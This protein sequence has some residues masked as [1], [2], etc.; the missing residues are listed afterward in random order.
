MGGGGRLTQIYLFSLVEK[1]D[2]VSCPAHS[3]LALGFAFAFESACT[4][5]NQSV[6]IGLAMGD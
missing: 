5:L 4:V 6:K 3:L 2:L 1:F